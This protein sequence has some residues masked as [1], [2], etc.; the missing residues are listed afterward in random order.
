MAYK[1]PWI[2]AILNF[3]IPGTGFLYLGKR[4]YLIIGIMLILITFVYT[5]VFYS[6]STIIFIGESIWN[7][8]W[9]ILGYFITKKANNEKQ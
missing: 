1:N 7:A 6:T 8:L 4:N 9:A 3:L 2:V 5:T